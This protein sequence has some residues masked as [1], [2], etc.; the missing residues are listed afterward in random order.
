MF[1]A[2]E[3]SIEALN[4]LAPIVRRVRRHDRALADQMRRAAGSVSHNL[5]E[6]RR[7]VG[8]DRTHSFRIAAGSA[9][10]ARTSLRVACAWGYVTAAE[11]EAAAA[12]LDRVL[13][14]TW[15]LTR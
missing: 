4:L 14:L 8:G 5:S 10:E 6:G 7:H 11:C 15:P 3:V 12:A 13:R 9:D 2:L 1:I